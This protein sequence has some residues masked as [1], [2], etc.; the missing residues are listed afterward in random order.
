MRAVFM[1]LFFSLCPSSLGLKYLQTM[2]QRKSI[3][4]NKSDKQ[5]WEGVPFSNP[6]QF[7][8]ISSFNF[9]KSALLKYL[10]VY[11]SFS[12]YLLELIIL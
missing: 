4:E 8:K 5:S 10:S 9:M 6:Q 2:T 1:I 12:L 3:E 7:C 11:T